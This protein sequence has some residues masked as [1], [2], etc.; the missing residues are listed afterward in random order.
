MKHDMIITQTVVETE[1]LTL[2]PI[3]RSDAGPL[4]LF[5]SDERVARMTRDIAHPLPPG[6]V[7]AFVAR[8][9]AVDRSEDVWVM[10]GS[11]SGQGNLL[12]LISLARLDREQSEIIYWVVPAFWNSGLASEAVRGLVEA[13]PLDNQTMFASVFQDNPASARVLTNAGF[14]YL[15]DAEAF[16]V[17]RGVNVPT[18]TY[19]KR[20][21]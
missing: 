3:R 4:E 14:E 17:S 11:T 6:S 10:D 12:G 7:D 13:N 21:K 9:Q 1:R 2:R 15:G 5:A 19:S 8:A 20:L 18:W 16:S